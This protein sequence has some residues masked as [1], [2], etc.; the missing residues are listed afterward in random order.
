MKK[1]V[2]ITGASSGIGSE[3]AKQMSENGHPVLLLSRR[4]EPMEAL[5]LHNAMCQSADVT[6][7]KAMREAIAAA[8]TV[9][10]KTD[11]LVNCVGVMLLDHP[12]EQDYEE[13]DRMIEV[14]I[15]GILTGTHIV[16]QDMISRNEGTIVN[17]SSIAG[18]KTF[19]QHST[20]C[21]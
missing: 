5:E 13:W 7:L 14:N 1:L 11:L 3:I 2:V 19:D 8:E 21:G 15:K 20:R 18:R 4:V 10:G 6:D 12:H 9:Y 17:I 16:L